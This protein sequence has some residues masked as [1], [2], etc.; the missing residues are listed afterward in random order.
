[1]LVRSHLPTMFNIRLVTKQVLKEHIPRAQEPL[2]TVLSYDQP[3][4]FFLTSK[5]FLSLVDYLFF[6]SSTCQVYNEPL[7]ISLTH[8]QCKNWWTNRQTD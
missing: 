8:I 2:G 6:T 4:S 3:R 7:D 1:M 5:K